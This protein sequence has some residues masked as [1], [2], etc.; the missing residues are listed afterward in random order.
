MAFPRAGAHRVPGA[1]PDV[2]VAAAAGEGTLGVPHEARERIRPRAAKLL[3]VAERTCVERRRT[4]ILAILIGTLLLLGRLAAADGWLWPALAAVGFLAA[5]ER[6]RVRGL[7]VLG[8]VLAG[9]AGGLLLGGLGIPGA[10]WVSLGVAV[11]A[12]DRV[13]PRADKRVLRL[14]AGTTAFGLLWGI[15]SAGWTWD[16][17]FALVL[18]LASLL[19]LGG[20][21]GDG[22]DA[23]TEPS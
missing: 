1:V 5:Y 17:R 6:Q 7:L 9:V 15:A 23:P 19:L 3:D 4:A 20:D 18:V 14:G 13:E 2:A 21:R 8:C 22:R 11:M 12:I 10:V 16:A